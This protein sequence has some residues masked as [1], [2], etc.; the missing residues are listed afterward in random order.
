MTEA[1]R[2][3]GVPKETIQYWLNKPEFAQLRTTAREIVVDSFWVGIQI[4]A[5][6][7]TEGLQSDAPLNHK[8]D[9]FRSLA[10]RYLLLNGE[11]TARSEHR[12]ISDPDDA[13]VDAL[14]GRVAWLPTPVAPGL[15]ARG[16]G[17]HT[18]GKH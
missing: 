4:G 12:D 3:T 18:N 11:A 5:K 6:A 2:Q 17:A 8:A 16:N 1:E 9:A 14:E 7:L 15:V 13:A 10:D